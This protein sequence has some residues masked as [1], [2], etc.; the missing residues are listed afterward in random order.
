MN[1]QARVWAGIVIA[2]TAFGQAWGFFADSRNTT[3]PLFDTLT[4]VFPLW[5]WGTVWLLVGTLALAAGL[6]DH[7]F[8]SR[9]AIIV[10]WPAA[11]GLFVSVLWARFVDNVQVSYVGISWAYFLFAAL[12]YSALFGWMDKVE[13]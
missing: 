4:G 9:M 10:G 13:R 5:W 12:G 6:L 7:R 11:T 3:S 1:L 2:P 8:C